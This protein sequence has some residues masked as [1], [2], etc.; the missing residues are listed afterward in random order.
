MKKLVSALA[1]IASVG[2]FTPPV[3]QKAALPKPR[4]WK[5]DPYRPAVR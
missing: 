3:R 5:R 2:M 1:V 4:H